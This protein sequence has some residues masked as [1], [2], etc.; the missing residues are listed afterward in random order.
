[1]EV[2]SK[3]KSKHFFDDEIL[4]IYP[5][6]TIHLKMGVMRHPKLNFSTLTEDNTS[7]YNNF[8]SYRDKIDRHRK[9]VEEDN[10]WG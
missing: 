2:R 4:F 9:M 5:D 10:D 6:G 7:Y 3:T 1:M 8:V